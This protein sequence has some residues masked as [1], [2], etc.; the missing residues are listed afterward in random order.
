MCLFSG[1]RDAFTWRDLRVRCL[2]PTQV[3]HCPLK[4][5][6]LCKKKNHYKSKEDGIYTHDVENFDGQ[7]HT[8]DPH[9]NQKLLTPC[10][11][12][13]LRNATPAAGPWHTTRPFAAGSAS[14][15]NS[16]VELNTLLT[17]CPRMV[18][19]TAGG[20]R[21]AGVDGVVLEERQLRRDPF[22]QVED[23]RMAKASREWCGGENQQGPSLTVSS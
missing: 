20:G 14:P 12:S 21:R 17:L 15:A 3:N 22:K 10:A 13:T 4:P 19:P 5:T 6:H 2:A 8:R 18:A 23:S 9:Q 1:P 16:A 11:S 7:N